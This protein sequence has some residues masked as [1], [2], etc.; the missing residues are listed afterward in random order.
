M[1]N[2]AQSWDSVRNPG[3][4]TPELSPWRAGRLGIYPLTFTPHPW[5]VNI[6]SPLG[7]A[8]AAEQPPVS[9]EKAVKQSPRVFSV[10]AKHCCTD[11]AATGHPWLQI[12]L[13]GPRVEH[14]KLA[15]QC[16]ALLFHRGV[17]TAHRD[18]FVFFAL[19]DDSLGAR[20]PWIQSPNPAGASTPGSNSASPASGSGRRHA[21]TLGG[22]RAT[23]SGVPADLPE[24]Q[25]SVA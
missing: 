22:P 20:T 7:C 21:A 8:F 5:R 2:G 15:G 19:L 6:T 4:H 9:S 1:D 3:E 12:Q 16:Q 23:G 11:R 17:N 10:S 14:S 25:C 18:L 13:E 24:A